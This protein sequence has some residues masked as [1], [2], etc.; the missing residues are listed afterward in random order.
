MELNK[1]VDEI[2]SLDFND[3]GSWPDWAH[4]TAVIIVCIAIGFAGYWFIIKDMVVELEQV[5]KEE[6]V[7]R[8]EFENKQKKV[9]NLE[10]YKV[11][12]EEMKRSFGAM[13]RQLPSKSEVANLLNDISQTRVESGL[14][15]KLFKPKGEITR[16][17][18]AELPN[19]L[20]VEGTFHEFGDFASNI[21]QLPRIVTL[22]NVSIKP[23]NDGR[24]DMQL[25]AKTY[26]YLEDDEQ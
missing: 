22:H 25:E 14:N 6:P 4:V 13:L 7:L 8:A 17:F 1:I 20:Q 10:A 26:R 23:L 15:E 2:N 9:A 16:D 5:E 3:V 24:L 12:L 21:A 19:D 18:Y 11:Q